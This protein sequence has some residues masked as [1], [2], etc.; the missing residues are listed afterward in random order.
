MNYSMIRY[1]LSSVICFVG[2]FL[3]LPAATA[4]IYQE[5]EGFLYLITGLACMLIGFWGRRRKQRKKTV[6]KRKMKKKRKFFKYNCH[7]CVCVC[8]CVFV[9]VCVF[10][11]VCVCIQ[12]D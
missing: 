11:G 6:E 10:V 9:C 2:I 1:I 4:G 8:M 5:K 7:L 3:L 12:Q